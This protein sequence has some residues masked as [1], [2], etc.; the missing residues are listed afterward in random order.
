MYKNYLLN[1]CALIPKFDHFNKPY[2]VIVTSKG[3][4]KVNLSPS[5]L[6][7]TDLKENGSSLKGAKEAS[8]ATLETASMHPILIP[9]LPLFH[10]WFPT[11]S[12]RNDTCHYFALHH[13]LKAKDNPL[14]SHS[15]IVILRDGRE[16][17]VPVSKSKFKQ[18]EYKASTY[19][20]KVLFKQLISHSLYSKAEEKIVLKCAE[21]NENYL[22]D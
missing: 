18:L 14:S 3:Q 11:E 15:T 22:L 20:A 13:V 10:V 1:A 7:D 17:A 19:F 6:I 4:T 21:Q 16:V 5:K 12:T 2:T 9:R 8:K